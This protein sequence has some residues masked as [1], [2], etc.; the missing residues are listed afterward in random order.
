[1][2]R[3]W[4]GKGIDEAELLIVATTTVECC[5]P[6]IPLQ[7]LDEVIGIAKTKF[8]EDTGPLQMLK[9]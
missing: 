1:M 7:D 6:L 3:D 2:T 9:C 8:G 4:S 5:L